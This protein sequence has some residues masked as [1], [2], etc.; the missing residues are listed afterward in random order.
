MTSDFAK[1]G[2]PA[3]D[4]LKSRIF[5][6]PIMNGMLV[7]MGEEQAG[8]A[9]AAVEF[10]IQH[11][12]LWSEWYPLTPP[13]RSRLRSRSAALTNDGLPAKPA[14]LLERNPLW[15]V[16]MNFSLNFRKWVAKICVTS[17]KV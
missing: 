15:G 2:G 8:G 9:D 3:V 7:W 4:Y 13:P 11:E 16:G 17:R 1:R 10:L 12:D 14:G 5:P 6:G